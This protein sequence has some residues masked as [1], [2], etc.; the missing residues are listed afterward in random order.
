[1]DNRTGLLEAAC[2]IL[3]E[4]IVLL[5]DKNHVVFW[6]QAATDLTGYPA[7]QVVARPC[8]PGLYLVDEEH[9][10]QSDDA[11]ALRALGPQDLHAFA[12]AVAGYSNGPSAPRQAIGDGLL[13][14]PTLVVLRHH[15]GHGVSA[16]LRR[17]A[18]ADAL[19]RRIGTS[20]LFY[21]VADT[22]TLPHGE[23]TAGAG[24]ERSQ[25]GME[26]RLD[27]AHHQWT[28]NRVPFGLLWIAIDQAA[29]MRRSHGREPSEAM[30]RTVEETLLR[31]LKPSE[32][33]GRWGDSEFL[34]LSHERSLPLLVAHAER[35]AGLTRTA[36]FRWWGD[37][38]NL[39]ASIGAACIREDQGLSTLLERA[40]QTMQKSLSAG[41]N[42][43]GESRGR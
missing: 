4:G 22:D 23:T 39:T 15:L 33:L 19:G 7:A 42:Q 41:G 8:P 6:N 1:M 32:T 16:M 21:P 37:R 5:D 34:V 12:G 28:T 11:A 43:V 25:A 20:L 2:N 29:P 26:D 9:R 3:S 14:R 17:L 27:E 30:L 24:I 13:E 18:L 35:L 38:V 31:G 40:R 36:D 10:S